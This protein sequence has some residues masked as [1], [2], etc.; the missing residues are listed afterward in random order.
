MWAV[1]IFMN[2]ALTAPAPWEDLGTDGGIHVWQRRVP[3]T[4]IIEVKGRA[5]VDANYKRILAVLHNAERRK[6]WMAYCRENY[7]LDLSTKTL[8]RFYVRTHVPL[9][10]VS[11]RDVVLESRVQLFPAQRTVRVEMTQVDDVRAP[12][13]AGVV[14]MPTLKGYFKIVR[15]NEA[16]T[17][18]EYQMAADPGGKIPKWL[19]HLGAKRAPIKTLRNLKRE[20][21]KPEY[22]N[23]LAFV[24]AA[25]DWAAF[26]AGHHEAA[27]SSD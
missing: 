3:G 13:R 7:E 17:G 25:F 4:S 15:L 26:E 20:L 16:R 22:A 18:I 10:F 11:D 19:V 21:H 24:E 27:Q 12:P 9:P 6:V 1:A 8:T 5:E 2:L 14:R 23:D